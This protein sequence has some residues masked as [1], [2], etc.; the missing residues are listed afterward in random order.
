M[1]T[2]SDRGCGIPEDS[3][4]K[5][6]Q[7]FYTTAHNET[8]GKRGIGLGLSICQS[9]VEAHGGT[10][11]AKNREGGGAEFIFTLPIGGMQHE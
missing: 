5:I 8:S 2:V 11:E 3:L 10:I 7:M 4:S 6:F 9:I 1:F